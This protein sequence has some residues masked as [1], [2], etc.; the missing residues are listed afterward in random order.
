VFLSDAFTVLGVALGEPAVVVVSLNLFD[1]RAALALHDAPNVLFQGAVVF[2]HLLKLCFRVICT[3]GKE[4]Q[5]V[6]IRVFGKHVARQEVLPWNV[7]IT[8]GFLV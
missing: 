1:V 6:N 5:S 7:G 3:D 4:G 8:R 2:E